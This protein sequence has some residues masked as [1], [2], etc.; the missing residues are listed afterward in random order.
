MWR[1]PIVEAVLGHLN[2]SSDERE[3]IRSSLEK[4]VRDRGRGSGP[5]MLSNPIN[6][7]IGTK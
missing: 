2:L 5:A 7:G 3:I 4:L 6:I 1:N